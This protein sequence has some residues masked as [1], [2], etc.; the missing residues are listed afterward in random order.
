MTE[1]GLLQEDPSPYGAGRAGPVQD[2]LRE[3][4]RA[5][6]RGDATEHTHRAALKGLEELARR[7]AGLAHLIRDAILRAFQRQQASRQP[8]DWR[9]AFAATPLPELAPQDNPQKE[10]EAVNEFADMFAQTLAYGLFSARVAGG[11]GKFTRERTQKLIPRTNPFLRAFFE[12][13]TGA[14]MDDE[15]VAGYVEDVIQNL[16]HADLFHILEG[17]GR[18]GPGRDPV[19]HFYETF[20]WITPAAS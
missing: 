11:A 13:I 20:R 17:F 9:Q 6:R 1:G 18:R 16:D 12:Q 3:F 4:E 10:T 14:A 2:Y 15:P 19:A 5:L 8:R 7:L